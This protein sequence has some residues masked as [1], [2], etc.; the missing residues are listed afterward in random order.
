MKNSEIT[1][2]LFLE[3]VEAIDSGNLKHLESLLI[4]HPRLIRN[5]LNYPV[6]EYFQHPYLLWF[7]ADNP[8]R[9][10]KLPPNIMELARL[11]I[12]AVCIDSGLS[13]GKETG[14]LKFL[15]TYL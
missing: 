6:D 14:G 11:L 1:D 5:R 8:I 10:D 15:L 2:P 12:T 3:A 9:I 13:F 7:V 4:K